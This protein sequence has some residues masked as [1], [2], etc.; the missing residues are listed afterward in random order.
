[1][2]GSKVEE[3]EPRRPGGGREGEKGKKSEQA[4]QARTLAW[5][6]HHQAFDQA[7]PST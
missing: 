7:V 6:P 4:G 5:Q 1:M 3:R 2:R